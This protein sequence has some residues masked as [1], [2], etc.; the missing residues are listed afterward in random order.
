MGRGGG[1]ARALRA[2]ASGAPPA[3][4]WAGL[5]GYANPI[6]VMGVDVFAL[7]ARDAGADGSSG[8]LSAGRGSR[9]PT[10]SLA[11]GSTSCRCWPHLDRARI[12]IG[13]RRRR[14]LRLLRLDDRHHRHRAG[15]SRR[16]RAPRSLPS[17]S[18]AGGRSPRVGFG[19]RTPE[20]ARAVADSADAVVLAAPPSRSSIGPPQSAIGSRDERLRPLAAGSG[21]RQWVIRPKPGFPLGAIF[22][23]GYGRGQEGSR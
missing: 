7:K 11:R 1:L 16:R 12:D 8:R 19:I 21:R 2:A 4:T 23:F 10:R 20:A 13:A 6:L 5:F 18:V 9:A 15:Q 14:Q 22:R 3:P 17:G